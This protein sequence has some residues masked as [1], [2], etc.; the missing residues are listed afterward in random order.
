M[1]TVI[2]HAFHTFSARCIPLNETVAQ[3][4]SLARAV[5]CEIILLLQSGVTEFSFV[6]HTTRA[7]Y[8]NKHSNV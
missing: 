2:S 7:I 4:A 1:L 3:F 8:T 5:Y 6:L